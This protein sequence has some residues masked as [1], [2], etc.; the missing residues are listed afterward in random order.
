MVRLG[1]KL[2]T[3][4]DKGS[5][6][7]DCAT[8]P[9]PELLNSCLVKCTRVVPE[10]R[11]QVQL[12]KTFSSYLYKIYHVF[13]SILLEVNDLKTVEI[14]TFTLK[15]PTKVPLLVDLVGAA[16]KLLTRCHVVSN[17]NL[18]E[19]LF[20]LNFPSKCASL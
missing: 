11:G 10:I 14:I 13:S 6:A 20:S 9:G 12:V 3:T 15:I 7:A 2:T 19:C 18:A 17:S 5:L 4:A 8:E 1:L 16:Q